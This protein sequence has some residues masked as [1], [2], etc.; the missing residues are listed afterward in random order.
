MD[1]VIPGTG[2]STDV[3]SQKVL[4]NGTELN[5][6]IM[7][8]QIVVSKSFNKIAS[9]RLTFS[10]GSAS[11]RDFP[12]SNDDLFK[13]GNEIEVQLGYHSEVETV[14]KGIIVKHAVKV[15]RQ[16]NSMLMIE[17]KDKAIK[18]TSARKS[19]YHLEKKDSEVITELAGELNTDG[20][21]A[22]SFTHKQL[23]Q[24][25]ATDWDFIITR[26]WH[27]RMHR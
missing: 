4:I 16:S 14:F 10:D 18:L 17:A 25:N 26:Q 9:A 6:E 11:E 22:T 3:V 13:P 2:T 19:I 5:H 15:G 21:E 27:A 7:L 12:L 1:S 23:V 20:V 8:M 24:Y